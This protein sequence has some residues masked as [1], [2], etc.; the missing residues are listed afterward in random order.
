MWEHVA[1]L[2][3]GELV[4]LGIEPGVPLPSESTIRRVLQQVDP[5][6]LDRRVSAWFRTLSGCSPVGGSSRWA[7]RPP[8]PAGPGAAPVGRL[9]S[10]DRYEGSDGLQELWS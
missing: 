3:A 2:T 6:E 1:A 9:G 4:E 5:T 10:R 8:E 7:T